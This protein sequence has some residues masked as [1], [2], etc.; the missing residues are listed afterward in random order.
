MPTLRLMGLFFL[1]IG[2]LSGWVIAATLT[3]PTWFEDRGVK[4][5]R[6]FLQVHLDWIIMGLILVA[7]DLAVPGAPVWV[8][9]LI[10]IGTV[11][12]P[13]LFLPLAWGTEHALH[14]AYRTIAPISFA[15]MSGG[16]TALF[17]V[18]LTRA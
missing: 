4:E 3:K 13:L 8:K 16:L 17:V 10:G 6:R 12:N 5:P 11:L 7:V 9:V 18:A 1:A 14:P 15:C 2:A